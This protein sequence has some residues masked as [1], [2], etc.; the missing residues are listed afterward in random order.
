MVPL[1]P[2]TDSLGRRNG[3]LVEARDRIRS[4]PVRR[5]TWRPLGLV[6]GFG[7]FALFTLLAFVMA[8]PLVALAGL[9]PLALSGLFAL[10]A[11]RARTQIAPDGIRNRGLGREVSS[12]GTRS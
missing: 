12:R 8:N 11:L 4:G 3:K 1:F 9:L 2:V 10:A 6:A 7:S 5:L